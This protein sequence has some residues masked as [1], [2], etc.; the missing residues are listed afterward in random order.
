MTRFEP[1]FEA[2]VAEVHSLRVFGSFI[3][4]SF[5]VE[6]VKVP[7]KDSGGESGEESPG[8]GHV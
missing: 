1:L 4:T 7:E 3:C 5:L 6:N 2:K 8:G